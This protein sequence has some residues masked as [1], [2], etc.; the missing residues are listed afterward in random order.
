M[1]EEGKEILVKAPMVGKIIEI[2]V[3]VG[4]ELK[5]GDEILIMESM[6][7]EIPVFCP[8]NGKVKKILVSAGDS[9]KTGETLAILDK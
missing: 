4:D 8:D 6:K 9:V 1:V 5:E 2:K 3:N 7:M